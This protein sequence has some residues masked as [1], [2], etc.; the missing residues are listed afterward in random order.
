MSDQMLWNVTIKQT[1]GK[2]HVV[3]ENGVVQA[4]F[5]TADD[6]YSFIQATPEAWTEEA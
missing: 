5:D 4:K 1:D 3:D 2:F 6:G